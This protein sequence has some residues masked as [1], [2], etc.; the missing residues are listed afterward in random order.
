MIS[1]EQLVQQAKK[2]INWVLYRGLSRYGFHA[3][4][5]HV[6]QAI[7]KLPSEFGFFEYFDAETGEGHGSESFSWTASLPLDLLLEEEQFS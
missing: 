4:A 6:K 2:Y 3:Y 5:E 1:R 7:I